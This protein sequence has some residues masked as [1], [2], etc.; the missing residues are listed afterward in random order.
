MRF[1]AP[2]NRY[3]IGLRLPDAKSRVTGRIGGGYT[4]IGES[5]IGLLPVLDPAETLRRRF[6]SPE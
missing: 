5:E 6:S 4:G 1:N 2:V 3:R